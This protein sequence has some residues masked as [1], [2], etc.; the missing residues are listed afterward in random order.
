MLSLFARHVHMR[1][2]LKQY[3]CYCVI[4]QCMS[5]FLYTRV[6]SIPFHVYLFNLLSLICL[7]GVRHSITLYVLT[8]KSSKYVY[9][10]LLY[11]IYFYSIIIFLKISLILRDNDFVQSNKPLILTLIC[12]MIIQLKGILFKLI[13]I[14]FYNCFRTI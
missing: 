5:I 11:M 10:K 4:I 8:L 3:Y 7:T 12:D 2:L 13:Y 6:Y 1:K 14:V 9:M